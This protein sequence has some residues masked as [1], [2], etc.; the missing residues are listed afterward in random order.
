MPIIIH[1]YDNTTVPVGDGSERVVSYVTFADIQRLEMAAMPGDTV[2][3]RQVC[4]ALA[5][6]QVQ[7]A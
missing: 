7:V 5:R 3:H 6:P 1:E 4:D 2:D